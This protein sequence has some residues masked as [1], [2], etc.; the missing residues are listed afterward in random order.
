[1]SAEV[2]KYHIACV[3]QDRN[4]IPVTVFMINYYYYN[5]VLTIYT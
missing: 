1:M 3:G 5:S 4:F 2:I